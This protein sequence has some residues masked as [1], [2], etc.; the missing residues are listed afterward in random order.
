[1]NL[2]ERTAKH[3]RISLSLGTFPSKAFKSPN[4]LC[5]IINISHPQNY[6]FITPY[7]VASLV[8]VRRAAEVIAPGFHQRG[9]VSRNPS[10]GLSIVF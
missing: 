3:R 10:K 7:L 6:E 8:E 5:Q 1:M 9:R 4:L 2:S